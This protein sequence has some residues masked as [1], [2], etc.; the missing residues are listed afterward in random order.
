M[1]MPK[2]TIFTPTYNRAYTITQLYASLLNQQNINAFE[3][4][5]VDDGST[6]NTK[7][8]IESF[9][10]E[11]KIV[12]RYFYQTNRGKQQAINLGVQK[13]KGCLFFIVDSDDYLT[14]NAVNTIL[15]EWQRI[16]TIEKFAGLCFRTK[17]YNNNNLIGKSLPNK[18]VDSNSIDI[19]YK[20]RIE[21]DKAEIF[22][23]DILKKYP[24]PSFK[25]EKFVP[26]AYIWNKIAEKY[27]L[28]FIDESIYMCDY[29]LDGYSKNFMKNLKSNPKGFRLYYS[30]LLRYKIVPINIKVKVLIR[31]IQ[32]WGFQCLKNTN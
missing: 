29:L 18:I 21:G 30:N 2:I 9:V 6:D 10:L 26:E 12:I 19:I 24:F 3:W 23:T 8:L 22:R 28:R 14:S 31:I 32:T 7:E 27:Q 20:Y 11:N 5:V 15:S 4:L 13:A 16:E 17:N 1:Q 25:K